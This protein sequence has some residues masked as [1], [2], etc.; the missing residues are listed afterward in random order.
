MIFKT[1]KLIPKHRYFF[2]LSFGMLLFWSLVTSASAIS[3]E[4]GHQSAQHYTP[5]FKAYVDS[6]AQKTIHEITQLTNDAFKIVPKAGYVGGY[7][8]SIHWLKFT[9]KPFDNHQKPLLM[10]ISPSYLD[11]VT[12]YIPD[13]QD[14]FKVFESGELSE[15]RATQSD[16]AFLFEIPD[17]TQP[18]TA[19]LRVETINTHTVVADIY[20]ETTYRKS[21]WIDYTLSGMYI[22]L[23]LTLIV[24]NFGYGKWR[25][26]MSFR[27]YLLLLITSLLVFVVSHGWL[28]LVTPDYWKTWINYLP[29]IMTLLYLLALTIFYHLLFEFKRPTTPIYFWISE[30][31][32]F[33]ITFDFLSLA[34]DFY[35]EFMPLLM[36][37]T[38]LYLL[39]ITGFTFKMSI[40]KHL[41]G[42][43]LFLA[44]V[45]G[46]SGV[47]GTSLSLSGYVSGGTLLMYSYTAGALGS[48]IFF[49]SI[50]NRRIRQIEKDH[51]KIM[52]EKDHAEAIAKKERDDKEQKAQFLSMLSHE[53]KTPLSVISMGM[54]QKNLSDTSQNHITQAIS[55]MS[56]VIDRC[57]VLE[58]LDN[59]IPTRITTVDLASLLDHLV[60][61]N[62]SASRIKLNCPQTIAEVETDDDWLRVIL[63]N[64]FDNALKYSPKDSFILVTLQQQENAWCISIE[65]TITETL[66]DKELIFQKYFRCPSAQKQTGSGLGLYIVKRLVVQLGATIDYTAAE[67]VTNQNNKVIFRLCLS[68]KD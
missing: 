51:V 36:F 34:F 16:R 56:M 49:Q 64:L 13:N 10:R 19:Y 26:N 46:F 23:L 17:I 59:Q 20:T 22:G 12:L 57:A 32:L 39:C 30:G 6:T 5:Q 48:I 61:H 4:R 40:Q 37:L 7:D 31:F 18:T 47:L 45:F 52:L 8:R 53:L 27:F 14:G 28:V 58:K 33:A 38:M 15:A 21:L 63:S 55:D 1:I 25:N 3:S 50:M 24:I 66:P 62:T 54:T 68:L 67:D 65:N 2:S 43:L 44:V 60:R 41:E 35:T 42:R 9:L 29:Q 11:Y